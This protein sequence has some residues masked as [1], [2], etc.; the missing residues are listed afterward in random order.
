MLKRSIAAGL[1]LAWLFAAGAAQAAPIIDFIAATDAV[2][3]Y[4]VGSGVFATTA[5]PGDGLSGVVT[6]PSGHAVF[7]ANLDLAIDLVG[8]E[9]PATIGTV[10]TGANAMAADLWIHDPLTSA[11]LLS[12]EIHSLVVSNIV[13]GAPGSTF[14]SVNFGGIDEQVNMGQS[15]IEIS[16]G[17]L[18]ADFGGVGTQGLMFMLVNQPSKFF[19]PGGVFNSSFTAAS[20]IQLKFLP[21]PEPNTALLVGIPMLGLAMW[22]RRSK[23]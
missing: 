3:G 15:L 6:Q 23:P 4:D 11:V 5:S 9:G 12:V 13:S 1:A 22:R 10:F 21:I 16:G 14:T 7:G 18:A 2:S 17:S 19:F 8:S 20:N